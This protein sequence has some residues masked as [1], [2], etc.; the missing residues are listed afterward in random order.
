MLESLLLR[1]VEVGFAMP[2]HLLA[3]LY[4]VC[5]GPK[6]VS[7]PEMPPRLSLKGAAQTLRGLLSSQ[8]RVHVRSPDQDLVSSSPCVQVPGIAGEQLLGLVAS[9][10]ACVWIAVMKGGSL[11]MAL[12]L[13]LLNP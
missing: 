9:V 1:L 12:S 6:C 7:L 10:R 11:H 3:A 5:R 8:L 4:I 13:P 2:S